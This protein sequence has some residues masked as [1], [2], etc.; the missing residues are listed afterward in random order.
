MAAEEKGSEKK[1]L[2]LRLDELLE[3]YL[4]TLDRYQKAQEQLSDYFS[5]GFLSLAQANFANQ[6]R[7]RYGQDYYDQRMQAIR[8]VHITDDPWGSFAVSS[9]T[10]RPSSV[11]TSNRQE[12]DEASKMQPDV[13]EEKSESAPQGKAAPDSSDSASSDNLAE[14]KEPGE[15]P[16]PEKRTPSDPLRWFGILVP[17][18]LRSSQ[19]SFISAVEGPIPEIATLINSIRKQEI[20]IG[21]LRKQI[22][23]L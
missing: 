13:S 1:G 18:A 22:R 8:T 20:E 10:P 2:L 16:K 5:K 15:T 21:R 11:S 7:T 19:S 6:S 4:N 9:S 23:K 3:E 12:S 17:S 14:S